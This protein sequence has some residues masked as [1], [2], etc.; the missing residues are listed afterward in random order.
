MR[1]FWY[2]EVMNKFIKNMPNM[3]KREITIKQA[4]LF[5]IV[6]CISI[7]IATLLIL[8]LD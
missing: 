6:A 7:T 4:I 2:D 3:R 5:F 1:A 8:S